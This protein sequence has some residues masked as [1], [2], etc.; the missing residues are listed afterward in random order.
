MKP[1]IAETDLIPCKTFSI[2]FAIFV[3]KSDW[4]PLSFMNIR[5]QI[6]ASSP[7]S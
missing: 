7:A 4:F 5:E 6:I 1:D 2:Y 3:K